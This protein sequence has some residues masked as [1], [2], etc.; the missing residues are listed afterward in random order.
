MRVI[1]QNRSRSLTTMKLTGHRPRWRRHLVLAGLV[2]AA[3]V[4]ASCSAAEKLLDVTDP[5]IINPT[6]V[7]SLEAADAVRLGALNRFALATTGAT[8]SNNG[9]TEFLV[10]GM[11]A[12]EWRSSDTFLERNQIDRRS[13]TTDNAEVELPYR[14]LN[15]VRLA[16]QLAIDKLTEFEGDSWKIAQ[17]NLL[18]AYVENQMAEDYCNALPIS[19]QNGGSIEYQDVL[20]TTEMFD[21]ALTH[22][23]AAI[24]GATGT[25]AD[26]AAIRE[27]AAVLRGR[28]LINL[29]R[30]ADASAAVAGVPTGSGWVNGNSD[31]TTYVAA[32][33]FNNS[34]ARYSLGNG[35]GTNGLDFAS[36]DPRVPNCVAGDAACTAAGAAARAFDP[37][38]PQPLRVQL[39]WPTR[40]DDVLL[41]TGIEARLIE[42]EAALQ[43]GNY[44][45]AGGT[46]EK[47][48]ALRA[49]VTGLA[50]LTDP[51]TPEG[52]VDQLFRE[53]AFWLFG[54]G[55]R[56]GD[57]R[58]LVRQY[59]R[60]VESVYPT[61]AWWKGGNY[62]TD[63][64]LQIPQ[65][66][67]GN[68]QFSRAACVAS[69]I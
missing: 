40:T 20:S 62:G 42:A 56:L 24:A 47:L 52:R 12:D 28:I 53:R 60:S 18:L 54:T 66:E 14:R 35:E 61:G 64:V 25:T 26:A 6:D 31:N 15:R 29:E 59:D 22:V 65:S 1:N 51:G 17:M 45:G 2:V 32:W 3:M 36:T 7:N 5:D 30:Y 34:A 19:T 27:A 23:D 33:F 68:P 58:R 9:D 39:A 57:L 10:S 69:E 48:N 55:H 67:E 13:V 21:L 37:L 44:G 43:A 63:V 50:P 38:T 4:T 46:L 8:S 49:T 41:M 16:A 11:L